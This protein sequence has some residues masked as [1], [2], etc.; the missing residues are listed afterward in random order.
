VIECK[1]SSAPWLVFR[2]AAEGGKWEATDSLRMNAV[3]ELD[4][5]GAIEWEQ[6]PWALRTPPGAA[7]AVAA[8]SGKARGGAQAGG[9]PDSGP[10]R[11]PQRDQA[12]DA[13]R[14]VV[15]AADGVHRDSPI[16]LT[17][18]SRSPQVRSNDGLWTRSRMWMKCSRGT[19]TTR[20]WP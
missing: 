18:A 19:L 5:L 10:G 13:I 20:S 17:L 11:A 9:V 8:V 15:S 16:T 6:D 12:F 7:F 4:I 3:S 14:Q 2:S 1:N